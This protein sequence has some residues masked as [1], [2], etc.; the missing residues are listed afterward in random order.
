MQA[1]GLRDDTTCIVIDILPQEKPAPVPPPKKQGK[2][3]FKSMFRKRSTESSSNI[4]TEY[5][6]PDV[7]VELFEEGS[8]MLSERSVVLG[9][10]SLVNMICLKSSSHIATCVCNVCISASFLS[11]FSSVL[12]MDNTFFD[13]INACVHCRLDSKYPL[14]NMFKLFMCAVCQIEVKPGEGISIHAGASNPGKLRPWDGP[15]LCL[16]CQEK[17]DAMEGRRPSGGM[18]SLSLQICQGL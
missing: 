7:V 15:F 9:Y 6:E 16:S 17:K 8:A 10:S 4:D 5:L 13:M 11:G 18:N 3:V 1:K 14:C 12:S 2:G